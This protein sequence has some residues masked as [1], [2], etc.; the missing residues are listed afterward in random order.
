[1][2]EHRIE[3]DVEASNPSIVVIAQAF[4]RPWRAFV[5]GSPQP[6]WRANYAFQALEVPPGR[7]KVAVLYIDWTYRVGLAISLL[8]LAA[9]IAFHFLYSRPRD[10]V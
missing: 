7:H 8:S 4:Y 1:M 9:C 6:L 2:S 3:A 10:P 5:D